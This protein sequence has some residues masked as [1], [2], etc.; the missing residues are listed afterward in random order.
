MKK[1]EKSW[2]VQ[3]A[4]RTKMKVVNYIENYDSFM[5]QFKIQVKLNVPPLGSYDVLTGMDWLQKH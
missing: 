3:L 4:T 2:M 1:F 5:S